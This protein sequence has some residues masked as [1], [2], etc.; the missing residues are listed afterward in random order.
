MLAPSSDQHRVAPGS[1]TPALCSE[2]PLAITPCW[3]SPF[4]DATPSS[5]LASAQLSLGVPAPHALLTDWPYCR[6]SAPTACGP[7]GSA[8]LV[9]G[10]GW[11][12]TVGTRRGPVLL[13]AMG[14]SCAG[15]PH[16]PRDPSEHP[17]PGSNVG[18]TH[19]SPERQST[20]PHQALPRSCSHTAAME[21]PPSAGEPS[22]APRRERGR[23]ENTPH[24]P[25]QHP[26]FC[27]SI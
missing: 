27:A 8:G 22:T 14:L 6:S 26:P 23:E 21:L 16:P 17:Q 15:S 9:H 3:K 13:V 18:T 2:P 4:R 11:C 12:R 7:C 25:P 20:T 5:S 24:P 19:S 1:I 10:L